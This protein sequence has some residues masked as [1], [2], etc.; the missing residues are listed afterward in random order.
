MNLL[1][2][3]QLSGLFAWLLTSPAIASFSVIVTF[4][5]FS[6]AVNAIQIDFSDNSSDPIIG[7]LTNA[8]LDNYG[9]TMIY[10][11]AITDG[12]T[13]LDLVV[14]VTDSYAP[15]DATKNG[16][17]SGDIGQINIAANSSTKFKFSIVE[18]G[19]NIPYAVSNIDFSL[20]DVDGNNG[21]NGAVEK[22]VL[23]SPADYSLVDGTPYLH[24][25]R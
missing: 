18:A 22:V 13:S 4:L 17:I 1:Y 2:L 7:D 3:K 19:T 14:E 11:N 12:G 21:N 15:Y 24:I 25:R 16:S 23:Y 20:L 8:D 9:A 6:P 5:L 10:Q